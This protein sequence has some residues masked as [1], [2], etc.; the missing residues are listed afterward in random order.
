MAVTVLKN[1]VLLP[2][3]HRVMRWM[4][5][6]SLVVHPCFRGLAGKTG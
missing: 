5:A 1:D 2:S 3:L 6:P 4:G